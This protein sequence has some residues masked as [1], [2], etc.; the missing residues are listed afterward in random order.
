MKISYKWLVELLGTDPGVQ[1]AMHLLTMGGLEVEHS[2]T[3]GA[4]LSPIRLAEVRS[5][6]PHPTSKNPLNL[7]TVS[8]GAD[9]EI[10]VVCGASNVPPAGEMVLFAPV[11]ATVFAKDGSSFTLIEKP[12]AG[13]VSRGM[14]C[15]EIE[16]DLG[17]D[18]DGI[19]VLPSGA[20]PA[21]TLLIDYLRGAQD[22]ILEVNVTPNRPDALGHIGVAR[23]L[24]ALLGRG[25]PAH[26]P[27]SLETVAG[28]VDDKLSLRIESDKCPLFCASVMTVPAVGRSPL[29]LRT[30]LHRLGV[31]SINTVVDVSNLVML[32]M[33]QPNHIYDFDQ[34]ADKTLIVRAAHEGETLQT[35]DG[36]SR[37]LRNDDVVIADGQKAIGLAGVMGGE[38]SG[39]TTKTHKLLLEAAS[40]QSTTVRKMAKHHGMHTEASHRFERGVDPAAP[41]H[42][43]A[44]IKE[45]LAS[46]AGAQSVQ[47]DCEMGAGSAVS[48]AVTLRLA[49]VHRVLGLQISLEHCAEILTR[50]GFAVAGGV[51]DALQVRVPT[52]R[53]DVT[54]EIDVIEEVGRVY[55]YDKVPVVLPPTS[56]A[57]VGA[58]K[59]YA[60]RRRVREAMTSIGLDEAVSYAFLSDVL[61]DNSSLKS[62][63]RLANPLGE[64][65]A[66]MRPS[67]LPG[68]LQAA[69][70]G[71]RY[72]EL[73]ARLFEVGTVFGSGR[74]TIESEA[75]QANTGPIEEHTEL[76]FILVGPRDAYLT[77][78][79]PVD[80]FDGK[81]VVEAL[82]QKIAGATVLRAERGQPNDCPT[83][84]H[85]A[86]WAQL[87][88]GDGAHAVL[89][90]VV[91]EL[92][93]DVR[94]KFNLPA[95]T[96]VGL[97][98]VPALASA[99][100]TPKAI[101]PSRTPTVRRDVALL[102]NRLQ[103]AAGLST[104]LQTNAGPHCTKVELFDRYI[105][106]ELPEQTHSLAFAL[107]FRAADRTLTETEVDKWVTAAVQ[108][109][110][111]AHGA[112]RR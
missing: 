90:G 3:V 108:A 86:A 25:L 14:L 63:A 11:G 51:E 107:Y 99:L 52:W 36:T 95:A 89:L 77:R 34:I 54:R 74:N 19:V 98:S 100:T 58:T 68:L 87:R 101:E 79:Q 109:A 50:L 48:P 112:Q 103:P 1:N 22:F 16:L 4:H 83:W 97:L 41:R 72:G 42:A 91:A 71:V 28:D 94:E 53:V 76:G 61:I 70:V 20:A 66:A 57:Q 81:G 27:Q 75:T 46:L 64:D 44:R 39:V 55:G 9:G 37:V 8:L 65:R 17:T 26:E 38:K 56:G 2:S 69:S 5:M 40:F 43:M 47:S 32:E 35:L 23:D 106:K 67:V 24:A 49:R 10:E 84:A 93:P 82:V 62:H 92:H 18:S 88:L 105:G 111:T 29:W 85:P 80:F 104:A 59:D 15:S 78:A 6:R 12:V 73:R 7:V 110:E 60:L 30:R 96:V 31:R 13:V 45:L 33:G 21:G 102:V